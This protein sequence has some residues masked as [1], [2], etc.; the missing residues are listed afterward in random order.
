NK[1]RGD[2][3]SNPGG[4]CTPNG[5]QD[6][7]LRP[8]GHPPGPSLPASGVV[9]ER[10]SMLDKPDYREGIWA[11]LEE[12]GVA[13]FPGARGRIPNFIGAEAA[14]DRLAGLDGWRSAGGV[15][16]NPPS[17][18]LPV[19]ARALTEGKL[20]FIAVPRLVDRRPFIK[21][22]PSRLTVKPRAAAS[23]KGAAKAGR[24]V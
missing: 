20:L 8:L 18:P 6:R 7:H 1:E 12:R 19:R 9:S 13:R 15:K 17:P 21:L 11:L 16:P 22:D 2:R 4:A 24:L 10:R 23:I 5:F 14:A 3:D